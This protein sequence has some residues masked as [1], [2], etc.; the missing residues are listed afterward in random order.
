M[1]ALQILLLFVG[2]LAALVIFL[3]MPFPGLRRPQFRGHR[4]LSLPASV[5]ASVALLVLFLVLAW[6]QR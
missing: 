6:M 1:N 3:V 5:L 2:S 4:P